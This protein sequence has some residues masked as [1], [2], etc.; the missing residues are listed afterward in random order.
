MKLPGTYL[1]Y[2]ALMAVFG[3]TTAGIH[4]GLLSVNLATIVLLFLMV[5]EMF[6]SFSAAWRRWRIR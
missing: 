4:L 1:A 5:R 3:Q 2:A 6:D